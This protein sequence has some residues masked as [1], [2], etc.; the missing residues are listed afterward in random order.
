MFIIIGLGWEP[1]GKPTDF[2]FLPLALVAM[3]IYVVVGI[4]IIALLRGD[5]E[6]DKDYPNE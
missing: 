2:G 3:G 6:E 1:F 4:N 5:V